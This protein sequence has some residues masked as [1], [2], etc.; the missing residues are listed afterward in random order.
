LVS[1]RNQLQ[2]QRNSGPLGQKATMERE[3]L[4]D[5]LHTKI[6]QQRDTITRYSN[7]GRQS[8]SGN[9]KVHPHVHVHRTALIELWKEKI[10]EGEAKLPAPVMRRWIRCIQKSIS[11]L[12]DQINDDGSYNNEIKKLNYLKQKYE[13]WIQSNTIMTWDKNIITSPNLSNTHN[14]HDDTIMDECMG[15]QDSE[16]LN[17]VS[18]GESREDTIHINT[19]NIVTINN[20]DSIDSMDVDNMSTE[21]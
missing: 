7:R 15:T 19:N 14:D 17:D 3:D 5:R 4:L 10:P 12:Q 21:A 2:D 20:S 16:V 9:A 8:N 11:N 6:Q 13:E 1:K 18:Y